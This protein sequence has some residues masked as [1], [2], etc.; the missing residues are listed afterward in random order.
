MTRRHFFVT[1]AECGRDVLTR[2]GICNGC[3]VREGY[4][5]A[6]FVDDVDPA[7]REPAEPIPSAHPHFAF[8]RRMAFVQSMVGP[9]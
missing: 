8:A 6:P 2:A 3:A 1:C 9:Q 7:S 5:D 4:V